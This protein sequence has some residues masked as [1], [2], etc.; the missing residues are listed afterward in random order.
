ME[1]KK[2]D[3]LILTAHGMKI[4]VEAASTAHDGTVQIKYKGTISTASVSEV[5]L[6][7][8]DGMHATGVQPEVDQGTPPCPTCGEPGRCLTPKDADTVRRVL[9]ATFECK[10]DHRWPME[11]P[12]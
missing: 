9:I 6:A 11:F 5:E 2:G 1:I 12:L 10:N 7:D 8:A 4:P 3:R